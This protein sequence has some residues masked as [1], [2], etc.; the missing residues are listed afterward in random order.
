MK[1]SLAFPLPFQ[2]TIF[3]ERLVQQ[4]RRAAPPLFREGDCYRGTSS[5]TTISELDLLNP[6]SAI[7]VG[8]ATLVNGSYAFYQSLDVETSTG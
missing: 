4:L 3:Y 6:I 8:E 2:T 5:V 1:G 7:S